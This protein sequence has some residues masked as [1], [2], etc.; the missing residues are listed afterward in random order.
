MLSFYGCKS[1]AHRV[2]EKI[3]TN[4]LSFYMPRTAFVLRLLR[5]QHDVGQLHNDLESM[6]AILAP[7]I[8]G[9]RL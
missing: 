1:E 7:E 3:G 4:Q 6:I 5:R 8:K 2:L 9:C